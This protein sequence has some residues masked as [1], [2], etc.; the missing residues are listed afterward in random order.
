M[1]GPSLNKHVTPLAPSLGAKIR[2][3]FPPQL[4]KLNFTL[5]LV[6]I[7]VNVGSE[8]NTMYFICKV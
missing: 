2:F 4:C 3:D 1:T 5:P 7:G 6:Y 8:S